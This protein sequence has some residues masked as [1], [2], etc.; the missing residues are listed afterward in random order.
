MVRQTPGV[1]RVWVREAMVDPPAGWPE[2]GQVFVAFM[3]DGD[4]NPYPTALEVAAVKTRILET[5]MTANTAPEDV[6]VTSPTPHPI[7]FEFGGISPDTPSMRAAVTARLQQFFR[8]SVDYATNVLED[9]YR[10][11]IHDTYDTQTRAR[12]KSFSLVSPSGN[13]SISSTSLPALGDV[14]F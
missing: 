6:V 1:T 8:E 7:D 2:E 9:D 13:V 11:A 3:R 5:C 12:L 10:A 14:S 4:S